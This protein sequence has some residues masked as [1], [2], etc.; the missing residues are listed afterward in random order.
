MYI[1]IKNTEYI[2]L[3]YKDIINTQEGTQ[4]K[5]VNN[6]IYLCSEITS[7]EMDVSLRIG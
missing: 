7:T 6:V 5:K 2:H 4:L 1:N 3:N